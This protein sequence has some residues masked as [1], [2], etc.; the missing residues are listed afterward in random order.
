[1]LLGNVFSVMISI[2]SFD[3]AHMLLLIPRYDF[4]SHDW[5]TSRS[6]GQEYQ[7]E[8]ETKHVLAMLEMSIQVFTLPPLLLQSFCDVSL[9][10]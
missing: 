6:P 1:M 3:L 8:G 4:G 10:Y 5:N 9:K 2:I 7:W